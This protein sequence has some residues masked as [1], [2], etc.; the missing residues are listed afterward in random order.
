MS[1]S[2]GGRPVRTIAGMRFDDVLPDG[3]DEPLEETLTIIRREAEDH[4]TEFLVVMLD[5]GDQ[6]A[7]DEAERA[8][9]MLRARAVVLAHELTKLRARAVEEMFADDEVIGW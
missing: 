2:D 7:I 1:T 5:E 3:W 9:S 4:P 6:A 8:V